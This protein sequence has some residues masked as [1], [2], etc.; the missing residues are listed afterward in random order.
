MKERSE[1]MYQPLNKL[2]MQGEGSLYHQV[3]DNIQKLSLQHTNK[4]CDE[5]IS[6]MFYDATTLYFES[7]IQDEFFLFFCYFNFIKNDIFI[8]FA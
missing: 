7:F 8:N 3:I 4:I 1:I 2:N 6:V 5:K